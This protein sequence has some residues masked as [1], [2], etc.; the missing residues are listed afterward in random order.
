MSQTSINIH[1]SNDKIA[2][3]ELEG[4][5]QT[6]YGVTTIR[7]PQPLP[8]AAVSI[9]F[10]VRRPPKDSLF[11]NGRLDCVA[12]RRLRHNI[13]HPFSEPHGM[14]RGENDQCLR[15]QF[16][17]YR[18]IRSSYHRPVGALGRQWILIHCL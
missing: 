11:T 5:S 10:L 7:T 12:Y 15:W 2:E 4:S 18:S 16:L 13:D 1:G 3:R 17:F 6:H 9:C 8:A 14:A